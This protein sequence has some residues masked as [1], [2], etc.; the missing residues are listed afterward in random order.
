MTGQETS[1]RVVRAAML[2]GRQDLRIEEVPIRDPAPGEILVE[3]EACGICPTDA[4]KY[5]IG[6]RDGV[7]PENLGHEW[8]GR[9]VGL[10]EDALGWQIGQ[11]VYGDTFAGYAEYAVL[12]AAPSEWSAGAVAVPDEVPTERAIFIEPLADCLHAV[13]DQGGVR[14]GDRVVVVGAGA[15]GLQLVA[16]ASRAGAEVLAVEPIAERRSLAAAFGATA[17]LEPDHWPDRVHEWSA[18]RGADLVIV[19]VG[20]PSAVSEAVSAASAGGTVVL[21]SGFGLDGRLDLD[22]NDIHYREL[23]LVGSEWIGLPPKQRYERYAEAVAVIAGGEL[24]LERLVSLVVG[25]DG[26]TQAF[27]AVA[28]HS[29]MKAM[30]R[31]SG[32]VA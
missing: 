3:I 21:F 2:H 8:L 31:P 25:F 6:T 13:R 28:D 22:L 7:Y 16:A 20:V 32:R 12:G 27:A 15:M 10:G 30:L 5:A 18:G 14:A 23:R 1:T 19:S 26:L 11:R 17:A 29:T 9:I 24:E 4:R